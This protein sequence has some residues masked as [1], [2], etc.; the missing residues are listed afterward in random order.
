MDTLIF[1]YDLLSHLSI[2]LKKK[3]SKISFILW[4]IT[5]NKIKNNL[6]VRHS[7]ERMCI[8]L[9][10]YRHSLHSK[11]EAVMTHSELACL[12]PALSEGL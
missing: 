7:K 12:I 11:Q 10:Q 4:G 8:C 6:Q 9:S 5:L 2:S 3:K 1:K